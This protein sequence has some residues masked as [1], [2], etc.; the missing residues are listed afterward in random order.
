MSKPSWKLLEPVEIGGLVLKNRMVM[1]PMLTCMATDDNKVS[2]RMLDYYLARA[3]G[4]IA[5]IISEYTYI[6]PKASKA[7]GHQLGNHGEECL[8][9]LKKLTETIEENG[10]RAI[11]QLCHAG[12]QSSVKYTGLQPLAPSAVP[13]LGEM[14]R[15]ITVAEIEEVE[16]AFAQAGDRAKRAGFS[17][18]EIHGANGYLL[19][20]FLSP[21]TNRRTD[22]YGGSLENRA[23]FSLETLKRLRSRVDPDFVVGYRMNG[24]DYLDN[25]IS[26]ED[27]G[28]FAAMLEEAGADYV[29]VSA[30]MQ[31]SW[32][33]VV[34]P[35]YIPDGC[36]VDLAKR[37][38]D[39]VG[40]PVITVGAHTVKTAEQA[41]QEEKADLV[42][43]G[44][45]LIA[46]PE[47]PNKLFSGRSE[48]IRPCI[49]GNEGCVSNT[50]LDHPIHCEVN[51]AAGKEIEFT[52]LPS[53]QS[54]EVL[55]VGGGIAGLEAARL[56]AV[57]GHK[58]T[59][60][61]R[62]EQLGGHLIEGCVPRFKDTVKRLLSWSID[63]VRKF[64]VE[65]LK[66]TKGTPELV[67]NRQ[68][69][70]LIVAVGSSF[71]VPDIKGVE[72]PFVLLPDEAFLGQKEIGERVVIIGGGTVGCELALYLSE[73][74]GRKTAVVEKE[75][76]LIPGATF[77]NRIAIME[78]LR[79]VEVKQYTGW[80]LTE[81]GNAEVVGK[82][83]E[84]GREII[85]ADT[86]VLCMGVRARADVA[87]S[88]HGFAPVVKIIGDCCQ[89][90]DIYHSIEDSWQAVLSL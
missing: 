88:F 23:R 77:I 66:E 11:L 12:R 44:R 85:P 1:S 9:G 46:D 52:V 36:L 49:R 13:N 59:L 63:Q 48:D 6:D 57:K 76:E 72:Q 17:G 69:E 18:V 78:R 67:R 65:I 28:R 87:E 47:L 84:N 30:G 42:A 31:E 19:S 50:R 71:I 29:H 82:S 16:N 34:Q 89:A 2:Q 39:N 73:E 80:T 21:H 27:A 79:R 25:G 15:E 68:P 51:P 41:L 7:R 38:K 56:A 61:E 22:D 14:P 75:Q 83:R 55:V 10:A 86:V 81:I 74:L 4:G 43:F 40:I 60:L 5:A 24:A 90:R 32:H 54:K 26:L 45:S 20:Q 35:M 53:A 58:V 8:P 3:R 62:S 37:V 64:E 33:Y 70:V